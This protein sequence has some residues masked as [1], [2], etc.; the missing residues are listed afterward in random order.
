MSFMCVLVVLVLE[1]PEWKRSGSHD[2]DHWSTI[3]EE[4]WT[5]VRRRP[6]IRVAGC[7]LINLAHWAF[8]P[9]SQQLLKVYL[10]HLGQYVTPACSALLLLQGLHRHHQKPPAAQ[11][12]GQVRPGQ[13]SAQHPGHP[14]CLCQSQADLR[15]RWVCLQTSSPN[16]SVC[17]TFMM[18]FFFF[19][20]SWLF[21]DPFEESEERWFSSIENSRW[22]EYVR[23]RNTS[24]VHMA[25][26]AVLLC[27]CVPLTHSFAV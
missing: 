3:S 13:V 21:A 9:L 7:V 15:R 11:R 27:A 23:Y 6:L 2:R 1:S 14:V 26:G 10:T 12:R 20:I 4:V 25:G 17:L 5:E 8:K 22:L 24:T 18:D 16:A 19:S